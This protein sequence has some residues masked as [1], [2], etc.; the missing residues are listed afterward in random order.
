ML[1]LS[2]VLAGLIVVLD[3]LLK[4]YISSNFEL[5]TSVI[6]RYWTFSIGSF[7][8][9]SITHIR[10]DGAGWS[11]LGGQTIFLIAFTSIV[12]IAILV[13]MIVK[14]KKI[15]TLEYLALSLVIGGGVGNLVDRFRML[16]DP[17]FT[18]VVDYIAVDFIDFPVFNFADMCV[19]VGGIGLCLIY[20]WQE[21]KD[22]KAKKLAKAEEA[23]EN[24]ESEDKAQGEDQ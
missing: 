19:V 2:L 22:S 4:L 24:C 3:Q 21:S 6:H 5:C 14:R 8:V 18:G 7:D 11:I 9:F 20:I 23:K 15:G 12:L 17:D 13:Y 1:V 16:I 10:N